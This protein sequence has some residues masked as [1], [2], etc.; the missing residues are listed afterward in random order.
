MEQLAS[1]VFR[2]T[3]PMDGLLDHVHVYILSNEDA[4]LL[5]DSGLD[6][7]AHEERIV[8]ALAEAGLPRPRGV[9]LTHVHPDHAGR[10]SALSRLFRAPVYLDPKGVELLRRRAAP[11]ARLVYQQFLAELGVPAAEQEELLATLPAPIELPEAWQDLPR[12][13]EIGGLT[14]R[15]VPTPGHSPDHVAFYRPADGLLI[16]GDVVLRGET[17][18]VSLLP[19][20]DD[21]PLARYEASLL[22]LLQLQPTRCL[23]GHFEVVDDLPAE[24]ERIRRHQKARQ[25]D[26]RRALDA[27]G[28]TVYE[29]AGAMPWQGRRRRFAELSARDRRLALAEAAA[30]LRH[31]QRCQGG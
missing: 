27:G 26:L 16:S 14:W 19:D 6:E 15:V 17:P 18:N 2:L 10:A 24:V 8:A 12:R 31:F 11:D 1:G 21:D 5:I 13:L 22:R 25:E 29:L 28:R 7:E 30:H 20:G 23:P 4:S 3:L 9:L